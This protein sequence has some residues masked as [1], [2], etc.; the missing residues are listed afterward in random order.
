MNGLGEEEKLTQRTDGNIGMTERRNSNPSQN[1]NPK[2]NPKSSY[3]SPAGMTITL[4]PAE[5][6]SSMYNYKVKITRK[7]HYSRA[8]DCWRACAND[9]QFFKMAC[10]S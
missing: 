5:C 10:N 9:T 2:P 4:Q 6:H 1:G 3:G 8:S 7:T